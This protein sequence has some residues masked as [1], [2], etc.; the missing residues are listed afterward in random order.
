[1]F[2]RALRPWG[3][4]HGLQFTSSGAPGRERDA[5]ISAQEFVT[6]DLCLDDAIACALTEMGN[7]VM[8]GVAPSKA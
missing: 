5:P 4:G 8:P 1:M 6:L 7:G 3:L 2:A